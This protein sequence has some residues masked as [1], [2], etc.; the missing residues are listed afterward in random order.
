VAIQGL[1]LSM[2]LGYLSKN[3]I[4]TP[5][6]RDD[7][8]Q[9]FLKNALITRSLKFMKPLNCIHTNNSKTVIARNKVTFQSSNQIARKESAELNPKHNLT[10]R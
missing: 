8:N 6:A 10:I 3:W 4:A 1:P 7:D 2:H 5:R 9:R